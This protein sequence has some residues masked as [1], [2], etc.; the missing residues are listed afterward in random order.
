MLRVF[1]GQWIGAT[2]GPLN[3]FSDDME[4]FCINRDAALKIYDAILKAII[5][6]MMLRWS[7]RARGCDDWFMGLFGWTSL[8]IKI[9]ALIKA[10]V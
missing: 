4:P 10:L 3:S 9:W 7:S 1:L 6:T 2:I 8:G 5:L